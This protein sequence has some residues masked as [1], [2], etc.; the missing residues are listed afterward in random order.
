VHFNKADH[1]LGVYELVVLE[2]TILHISDFKE[3][4]S[5][6][7]EVGHYK[8]SLQASSWGVGAIMGLG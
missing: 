4:R 5:W 2:R 6:C 8:Q 7:L 1:Y 3:Y